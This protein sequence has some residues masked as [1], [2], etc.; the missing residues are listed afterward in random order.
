[1]QC[2]LKF[3]G[4]F[5]DS[6]DRSAAVG[7][8]GALAKLGVGL[9]ETH[10]PSPVVVKENMLKLHVSKTSSDLGRSAI[11]FWR[12]FNIFKSIYFATLLLRVPPCYVLI[13][14]CGA[15]WNKKGADWTQFLW[16]RWYVALHYVVL[17]C[18]ALHCTTLNQNTEV[19]QK[20]RR[21]NAVF[22]RSMIAQQRS[23]KGPEAVGLAADIIVSDSSHIRL[24]G[25]HYCPVVYP[26]KES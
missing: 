24:Q 3:S 10:I 9:R 16:G 26:W 2:I 19:E 8:N 5:S 17:H 7:V 23:L 12:I 11:P 22:M 15:L 21:L 4:F 6:A 13:S 18:I 1:M 20:R 25:G 14:S